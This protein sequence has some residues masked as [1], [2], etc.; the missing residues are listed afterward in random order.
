MVSGEH[1]IAKSD[2][3]AEVERYMAI[4]GQALSYKIGQLKIS[5]LRQHASEQVPNFEELHLREFHN[6]VL[7]SGSLPLSILDA[8]IRAWV[9]SKQPRNY[10]TD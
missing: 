9:S 8:K 3:E 7:Q 5:E 10:T 2:I 4:P 6:Q 1:L